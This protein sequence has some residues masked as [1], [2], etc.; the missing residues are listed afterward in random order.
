MEAWVTYHFPKIHGQV[1]SHCLSLQSW[2]IRA[3][4]RFLHFLTTSFQMEQC[5]EIGFSYNLRQIES[6][7]NFLKER[8]FSDLT[9]LLSYK[10]NNTNL[11]LLS[12]GINVMRCIDWLVIQ[13]N[14]FLYLKKYLSLRIVAKKKKE[15]AQF[16]KQFLSS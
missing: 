16:F 8:K 4:H 12:I 2:P 9:F 1:K 11:A 10:M 13:S 5:L 14:Y 7:V 6:Q 15:S 3:K